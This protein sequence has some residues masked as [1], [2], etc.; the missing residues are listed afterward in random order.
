MNSAHPAD[1]AQTA[2]F[3]A[4]HLAELALLETQQPGFCRMLH[5]RFC[6]TFSQGCADMIAALDARQSR[7][8]S[9]LAHRLSGSAASF[10]AIGLASQYRR[11]EDCL[12][13][14]ECVSAEQIEALYAQAREVGQAFLNWLETCHTCPG[15]GI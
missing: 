15:P 3:D 7:T 10:G 6:Q 9:D 13:R 1:P 5:E 11:F 12:A 2:F 4:E 14:G 8:L